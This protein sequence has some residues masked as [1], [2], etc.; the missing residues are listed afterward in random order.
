[1]PETA[2]FNLAGRHLLTA[3]PAEPQIRFMTESRPL[4][5]A[6][7]AGTLAKGGAE[8]QLVYIATALKQSRHEVR[9]YCPTKDEFYQQALQQAGCACVWYGQHQNPLGRLSTLSRLL[10]KF[11]PHVVQATHF[12]TNLY[13]ALYAKMARKTLAFGCLRNDAVSE[14]NANGRWGKWLIKSPPALIANSESA[15][16]N[17]ALFGIQPQHVHVLPNVIDLSGFDA[18]RENSVTEDFGTT[19][20]VITVCRLVGAKRLDRF[21]AALELVNRTRKVS[22]IIIGDGRRRDELKALARQHGLQGDTLQFMGWRDDVPS[23]LGQADCYVSCSDHEGFPNALLEA[24]SA[25][26]PAVGTPAGDV[27]RVIEDGVTGFVVPFDD[28][29]ALAGRMLQLVDDADLRASM[30]A[31]ARHRVATHYSPETLSDRLMSIYR[32]EYALKPNRFL[33]RVFAS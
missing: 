28:T 23:L 21:I 31:A 25:S 30:G 4:R 18:Q 27:A 11:Q 22:G 2:A 16:S 26:V 32:A 13:V 24:M 17:S 15:K 29:E 1:M 6:L 8:K 5:I 9:V 33:N 3:A 10:H 14:V 7:V 20:T 12:Y 19:P